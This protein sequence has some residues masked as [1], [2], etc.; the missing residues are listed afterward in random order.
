LL[1]SD[2]RA[3]LK[4]TLIVRSFSLSEGSKVLFECRYL[5]LQR[6]VWPDDDDIFSVAIRIVASRDGGRG[7]LHF[8]KARLEGRDLGS[9]EF[10]REAQELVASGRNQDPPR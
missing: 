1:G 6:E 10:L 9:A 7:F 5:F 3:E 2:V 8:W 4:R